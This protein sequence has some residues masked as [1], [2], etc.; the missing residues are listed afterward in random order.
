MFLPG[1]I[2]TI[3]SHAVIGL[4]PNR[5][6]ENLVNSRSTELQGAVSWCGW[7]LG[8]RRSITP[9]HSPVLF[10]AIHA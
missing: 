5:N 10:E 2:G 3:D 7:V 9:P 6:Q 4:R 8:S 1:V